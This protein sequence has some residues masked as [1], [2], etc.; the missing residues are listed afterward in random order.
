MLAVLPS[1]GKL[2][3]EGT[4]SYL[5]GKVMVNLPEGVVNPVRMSA[6]AYPPS[7]PANHEMRMASGRCFHEAVST[8]PQ[9]LRMTATCLP[10]A[11]KAVIVY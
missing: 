5:M 3:A 7:C 2:G 11:C 9:V 10:A 8:T 1:T 4:S 6:T